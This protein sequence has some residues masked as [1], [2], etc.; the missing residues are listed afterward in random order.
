MAV[1]G[2][3]IVVLVTLVR[4]AQHD[5]RSR[6]A[7]LICSWAVMLVGFYLVA[8]ASAIQPHY[9]R[10]GLCLIAPAIALAARAMDLRCEAAA[11]LHS[12]ALATG[13]ALAWLLVLGFGV[14]YFAFI[15]RTGG[16][17][18]DTFRTAAV[19][20]KTAAL[21]HVLAAR[22]A[23]EETWIIADE[24]WNHRPLKYLAARQRGM[25]VASWEEAQASAAFRTALADARVWF[26][27]FAGSDKIRS[28]VRRLE[29]AGYATQQSHIADYA[30]RPVLTVVRCVQIENKR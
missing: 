8:G 6:E 23:D 3:A 20:P 25:H 9:E 14:N 17:S 5:L 26:I 29:Q 10:Y 21:A 2:V 13:V 12:P 7:C 19:E 4:H 22:S 28:A 18:H 24:Y 1:W 27:E 11:K 30:G 15:H 16:R